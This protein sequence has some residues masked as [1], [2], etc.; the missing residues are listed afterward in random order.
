MR[1]CGRNSAQTQ[2]KEMPMQPSPE[3]RDLTNR[4]AHAVGD[5]DMDFLERHVSR[6]ADV[7]FL[8]TDP[9]EW[10]TDLAGLRQAL[11]AQREAGI[12]VIPS[13]P[14]AY[15]EGNVGWAVDRM[16]RFRVGDQETPF[17]FSVVYRREDGEWKMV[18]FH[19]SIAVPNEE[20]LGV[21][22]PDEEPGSQ[23][24]NRV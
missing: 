1:Q 18:H 22:L 6:E 17:R 5:G 8:G 21:T 12:D 2:R 20:A 9:D 14:L 3:L 15:Q 24:A 13:D 4:I 19:S 16:V 10:W 11:A 7:A 23:P